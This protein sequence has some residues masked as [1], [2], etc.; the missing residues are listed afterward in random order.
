MLEL[1]A[2]FY[3]PEIGR[4]IQQ[5]PIGDGINLRAYE[6]NNPVA[7]IGPTG[8]VLPAAAGACVCA[9]E[10]VIVAMALGHAVAAGYYGYPCSQCRQR[11]RPAW[12]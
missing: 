1:G 10:G 8:E 4:F 6:G 12:D 3:W 11:A 2:R 5:D 7:S 9:H